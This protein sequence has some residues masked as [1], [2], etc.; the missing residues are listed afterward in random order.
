MLEL[1]IL[2]EIKSNLSKIKLVRAHLQQAENAGW[3]CLFLLAFC[4]MFTQVFHCWQNQ[5]R[6]KWRNCRLAIYV[7]HYVIVKVARIFNG[8]NEKCIDAYVS[9]C[10]FIQP[11]WPNRVVSVDFRCSVQRVPPL[12][13]SLGEII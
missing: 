8:L 4:A 11:K 2:Q 9:S 13:F 10:L 12:R 1:A 3:A 7:P 6:M 5:G